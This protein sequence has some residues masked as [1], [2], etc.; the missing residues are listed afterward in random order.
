MS[1]NSLKLEFANSKYQVWVRIIF[2]CYLTYIKSPSMNSNSSTT[3][4]IRRMNRYIPLKFYLIGQ[5]P[6][7]QQIHQNHLILMQRLK[8]KLKHLCTINYTLLIQHFCF[9][10]GNV[11]CPKYNTYNISN[12]T[13]FIYIFNKY[14][15]MCHMSTHKEGMVSN[16]IENK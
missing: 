2:I 6:Y 4:I 5:Q 1:S 10:R 16:Q 11:L 7:N 3:T 12:F 9:K 13:T 15:D 8:F 14:H